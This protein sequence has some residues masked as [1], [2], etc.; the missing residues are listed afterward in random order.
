MERVLFAGFHALRGAGYIPLHPGTA[1]LLSE[2]LDA[3]G[4][5]GIPGSPLFKPV[6]NNR[7][8]ETD[9]A[10]DDR[11]RRLQGQQGRARFTCAR[12]ASATKGMGAHAPR[13]TA[14]TNALLNN[15]DIAKVQEWFG[16]AN[17]ATTRLY[18]RRK[19]RPEDSP[20]FRVSY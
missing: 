16:H 14:G 12:S 19:S 15:A 13:A 1:E 3:L 9:K 8:G 5:G 10:I 7:T 18:D 20:T 4:H 17:I 11:R 6:R 2:Y